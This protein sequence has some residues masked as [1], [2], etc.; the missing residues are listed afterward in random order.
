MDGPRIAKVV[1]N[2]NE[3]PGRDLF[4]YVP[5]M[6]PR[7]PKRNLLLVLIYV[8]FAIVVVGSIGSSL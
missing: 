4:L 5:G 8:F 6:R 1:K 3:W 2:G 7:A